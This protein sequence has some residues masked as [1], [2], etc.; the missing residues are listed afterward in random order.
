MNYGSSKQYVINSK[1]TVTSIQNKFLLIITKLKATF[2]ILYFE[3]FC[4][5]AIGNYH[6][7]N[8]NSSIGLISILKYS[9]HVPVLPLL[10][11]PTS[12]G[13]E[14]LYLI[15]LIRLIVFKF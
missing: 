8:E 10:N 4:A 5:Q 14:P 12:L 9:I 11:T 15:I 6:N 1:I 3:K 7:Y 2:L 13:L